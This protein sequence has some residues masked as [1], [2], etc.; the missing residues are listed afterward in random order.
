MVKHV[1]WHGIHR[2]T[3]GE[4]HVVESH[5]PTRARPAV[6]A[7]ESAATPVVVVI[8][9]SQAADGGHSAMYLQRPGDQPDASARATATRALLIVVVVAAAAGAAAPKQTRR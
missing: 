3:L 5:P 4:A 7:A 9:A 6:V 8:Q 2:P 1:A